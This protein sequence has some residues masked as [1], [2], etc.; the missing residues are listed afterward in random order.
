M[1]PDVHYDLAH[2]AVYTVDKDTIRTIYEL[3]AAR[4]HPL[5]HLD[6]ASTFTSGTYNHNQTSLYTQTRKVRWHTHE[7]RL[8]NRLTP[9][10]FV[11][12]EIR[13]SHL[14]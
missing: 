8:P 10:Q 13:M 9:S 14:P 1:C 2:T 6:I 3:A 11:W 12:H 4:R 7:T 5:I